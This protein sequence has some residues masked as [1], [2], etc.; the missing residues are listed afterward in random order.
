MCKLLIF[1]YGK[2]FKFYFL[3]SFF[4]LVSCNARIPS[5]PP[6]PEFANEA[7]QYL[8]SINNSNDA[9]IFY[10]ASRTLNDIKYLKYFEDGVISYKLKKADYSQISVVEYQKDQSFTD[11]KGQIAAFPSESLFND[12]SKIYEQYKT[13]QSCF[14]IR[15]NSREK[16]LA[17]NVIFVDKTGT[18][19]VENCIR[20]M[21]GFSN[22]IPHNWQLTYP[23]LLP[24]YQASD[25]INWATYKCA[26]EKSKDNS[27][28]EIE[29]SR[30][31]FSSEPSLTCIKNAISKILTNFK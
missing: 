4:I 12:L 1:Y 5:L 23:E 20:L 15:F 13:T 27:D 11:I 9:K 26:Y 30:A 28:T 14:S 17:K 8:A 18:S 24:K 16:W 21:R 25:L 22:G 7:L 10:T 6:H 29:T 19:S 2:F 31:G 3:L